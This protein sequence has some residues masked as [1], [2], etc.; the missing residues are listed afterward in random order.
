VAPRLTSSDSGVKM[1]LQPFH[2]LIFFELRRPAAVVE[3]PGKR[4]G[5]RMRDWA[6]YTAVPAVARSLAIAMP[7]PQLRY[8]LIDNFSAAAQSFVSGSAQM[9]G[10]NATEQSGRFKSLGTQRF[11]YCTW[12]FPVANVAKVVLS[13]KLF[14]KEHYARTGYRCDMPTLAFKLNRDR[15]CLLSPSFDGP[16]VTLSPLSTQQNGWDDFVFDFADFAMGLGGI[17]FFNQ[18]KNATP[19]CATSAYNKR[20]TFFNNVRHELDPHDRLLN[21]YFATYLTE[22]ER[23]VRR[24][25]PRIVKS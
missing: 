6:M 7:I 8:P 20:L 17:P 10:S 1:F 18:T 12:A 9:I 21:S 11:R 2:D 4:F 25:V 19:E 16:V 24:R 15:S 14:S 5:W 13:Y 22:Q 3:R 23:P